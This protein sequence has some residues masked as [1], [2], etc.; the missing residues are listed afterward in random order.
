MSHTATLTLTV[1][2]AA[3]PNF[4]LSDSPGSLS[5]TQGNSGTSTIT[6]TPQNGFNGSVALSAAGL[7]SG[8]TASFNPS[9]TTA[10]STLTLTASSTATTGTATVTVTGTSGSLSH[11]AT[12]SLTVNP[13]STS[14]QL[15]GNT[16]FE[17]G[18]ATPW[19]ASSGV[20]SNSTTEPP[21]AGT[22][23]AWLDGYG[24][25]T[26]D[27]LSQTVT[28]PSGKTSGTLQFYLHIDT[29]ETGSTA[30]DKLTV[31]VG[32]T[33]VATFSN[34]NAAAG[35]QVH[36][37]NVSVTAGSSVTIKFTGTEDSSLQTSFVLDDVTFT[38]K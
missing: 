10:S 32:S 24:T 19:T 18:M 29:A 21:H 36:S 27:T 8:V 17:T 4:A 12:L 22:W 5:I 7:P 31:Q 11:A 6:V 14:V 34:V 26:T 20:V 38:V 9:S 25:T 37:Y 3:S 1:N 2:P 33:T 16:G 23:D 35:Y 28:I 30:Y 15:L 13:A